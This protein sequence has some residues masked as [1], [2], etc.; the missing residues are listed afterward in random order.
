MEINS[1]YPFGH[2]EKRE[3]DRNSLWPRGV[4]EAEDSR[5]RELAIIVAVGRDLAIGK[6]NDLIRHLPGDLARFKELTMGHTVIMGR[7]TW[8]S[9]PKR[10]LPG[11]RNIVITRND[12]YVVEGGERASSLEDALAGVTDDSLPFIIGGGEIYA[13]SLPLATRL[14]LTILDADTP[15]ADTFFPRWD[16]DEW[17]VTGASSVM[18]DK[19]GEEY[20]FVDL[21]RKGR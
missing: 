4:N 12:D 16:K 11:R 7:R 10:P 19:E 1:V 15:D 13:K 20:R 14:Y 18:R 5:G 21:V 8:E 3:R 17:R 6:D 2:E 9:L